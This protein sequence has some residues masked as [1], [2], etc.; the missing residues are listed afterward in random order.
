MSAGDTVDDR[1]EGDMRVVRRRT[2]APVRIAAFNLGEYEH[3]KVER[4]GYVVDVYANRKLEAALQPRV[5]AIARRRSFRRA[6]ASRAAARTRWK[7]RR[8]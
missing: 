4:G 5:P 8:R 1:I 7:L 3:A 6:E 2:S